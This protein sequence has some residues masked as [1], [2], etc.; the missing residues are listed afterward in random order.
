MNVWIV[1][2]G[3]SDLAIVRALLPDKIQAASEFIALGRRS[4][5]TSVARTVLVKHRE[6]VAVVV[7]MDSLDVATIREKY[8]TT[9]QLLRAVSGG[10]PFKVIPCIPA[11]E[12]IFF[13]VPQMLQRIFPKV[14][15]SAFLMFFSKLPKDALAF[16]FANGGGP[17]SLSEFLDALTDED[18]ER[19]QMTGPI[20]DLIAFVNEVVAP[21]GKRAT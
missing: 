3:E 1:L 2:E 11:L 15:L 19:L 9:E 5:I 6:P 13:E 18:V 20:R 4:N 7:D 12:A 16:L 17:T 14:Q 21:V 8:L 10:T